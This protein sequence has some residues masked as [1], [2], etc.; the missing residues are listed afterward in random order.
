MIMKSLINFLTYV[1]KFSSEKNIQLGRWSIKTCNTSH[2][3]SFYAN[4]DHCGDTICKMPKKYDEQS[5]LDRITYK[6]SVKSR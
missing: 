4:R 5:Y 2:A 6:T 1:C 3:S